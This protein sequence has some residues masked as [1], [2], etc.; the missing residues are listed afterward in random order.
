MTPDG[1]TEA[2]PTQPRWAELAAHRPLQA[3][4]PREVGGY[5][6]RACL[7]EGGMG[8]VYLS[9]TP[10]GRPIALKVIRAEYAADP[11]FRRRFEQEVATAQRVQGL[12]TAPVIDANPHSEQP[13]LATAYVAGPSLQQA[14]GV[15]GPL[16]AESVLILVAGVAEALQSIHAANVVHRDLKPSNVILAADG[17]RVIDFGIARA[18]DTTS[19]TQAGIR[20]GTPAFMAPEQV[21]G[22]PATPALDIFALGSLAVYAA[23]GELPFGGG[24]DPAVPYRILEEEP[25]LATCPPQL[26]ELVTRCLAK[27]PRQRPSPVQVIEL[28]RQASTGTQLHMGD[29]WLP[30]AVAAAVSRIAVTPVPPVPRPPKRSRFRVAAAVGMAALAIGS[31]VGAAA[32]AGAFDEKTPGQSTPGTSA[33]GGGS[34]ANS[35]DPE[36]LTRVDA[37]DLA[38]GNGVNLAEPTT[39]VRWEGSPDIAHIYDNGISFSNAEVV[40]LDDD[41]TGDHRTCVTDTR[42]ALTT[43]FDDVVVGTKFCVLTAQRVALVEVKKAPDPGERS[44]YYQLAIT[45]WRA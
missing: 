7:G 37:V 3:D 34:K 5:R 43:K 45:I 15:Y 32:I 28:C 25:D 17:P 10:G 23:T 40:L 21:R 22:Q 35:D 42:Y 31:G 27:D 6:L 33:A 16:P 13:W 24:L 2:V 30:P 19:V 4:D 1:P 8:R 29:G 41:Q 12:Y 14:V 20:V 11:A 38:L 26:R 18:V 39:M 36:V 44:Q 9:N